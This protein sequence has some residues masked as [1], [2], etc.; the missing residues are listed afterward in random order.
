MFTSGVGVSG[1]EKRYGLNRILAAVVFLAACIGVLPSASAQ[2]GS[3]CTASLLNRTVPVNADGSFAL[4]N[5]P[6]NPLSLYRVRVRCIAPN[7]TIVQGMSGFLNLNASGSSIDIGPISFTGFTYPPIALSLTIG[8]DLTTLSTVG[9][10]LQLY[11]TATYPGGT[12]LPVIYSDSGTTYVSS[13]PAVATVSSGGLVT[14]VSAGNVT[15]TALNEGMA[16]TVQ[17]QVLIALDTDGDGMPD[18]YEIANGFNPLNPADAGEDAD[19]DGLTNLQEYLLGTNPHNPD[20]DGDGLTD[21]Q[22]VALGTNPL[23]PDTDGDGL[24]DGQEVALG[25]NPLNP[26]TDGDGIPDGIEV[27]LGLNPLVPDPTTTVQGRV[28]DGSGNPVAGASTVVFT[29]FTGFTDATGNFSITFVPN[30]LGNI[31]V[32]AQITNNGQILDGTSPSMPGVTKGITNVG[33]IQIGVDAGAVSGVVTN[34][35]GLPVA[36]AQV[37]VTEGDNVRTTT[38]GATGSYLVNNMVAG[39]ITVVATDPGTGL[40]GQGT[41]VLVTGQSVNINISLGA[42]GTING[43]VTKADGVTPVGGA[44]VALSGSTFAT[45]TADPLG[46]YSFTFV[47]LGVFTIDATDSN[48]NH[49]RTSGNLFATGQT[50]GANVAFLG[51]GTVTGTVMDASG[52]VVPSAAITL[53]SSSVFGGSYQATADSNGKFSIAG[54]FVGS[55]VVTAQDTVN[56]L[57]GQAK[58]NITSDGQSVTSNISLGPAGTISGTVFQADGVTVVAGAQVTVTPFGLTTTTD[59]NGN[60]EFDILPVGTYRV[61]VT[62]SATGDQGSAS[63]TISSQDQIVTVNVTLNGLGQ[64][65]VTVIDGGGNEIAG[66][67]VALTSTT[68]FGGTQNGVTQSNGTVTFN[69]VLA[70]AFKV[71]ATNPATQLSGQNTG[72]VSVNTT[73]AI[74]VQL[75][76][77]GTIQ[78]TVYQP[79]GVTP[80]AGIQLQLQGQVSQTTESA[81]DGTYQFS[82]VPTSTYSLQAYDSYGNIRGSAT[83]IA[84]TT[85][86]QIVTQN[87]TLIGVGTVSGQITNPDGSVATGV[88][89]TLNTLAPGY[90]RSFN[91]QSDVNGNYSISEVPV[92]GFTVNALLESPTLLLGGSATGQMPSNSSQVTANIQ[93]AATTLPVSLNSPSYLY[94][95]NNFPFDIAANGTIADGFEY[96]FDGDFSANIG[97][98]NLDVILGSSA[99]AFT[100]STSGTKAQNG[101]EIDIQ[102]E[103]LAGLNVTRKVYVSNTG[104]FSRY[105]DELNNPTAG[106]I[107]IGVRFTSNIRPTNTSYPEVL[108]T[109]TGETAPSNQDDWMTIGD[110][111]DQDPM[112]TFSRANF[113]IPEL[114][115]VYQGS[116]APVPATT[117][118]FNLIPVTIITKI[119]AG[120]NSEIGQVQSEFDNITIPAGGTIAFLNFVAQQT[121]RASALASAQRLVQLPSEALTG[122]SPTEL[123][124]IV[125]FAATATNNVVN[126]PPLNANVAGEVLASDSLTPVPGATVTLQSSLPYFQRLYSTTSDGGGN[127]S[128]SSVTSSSGNNLIIPSATFTVQASLPSTLVQSPA[129]SGTFDP[130]NSPLF[131]VQNIIFSDTGIISGTVSSQEGV[132]ESQGTVALTG[133][134]FN[135]TQTTTIGADGSYNFYAVPPGTYTVVASIPNP[136]GTGLTGSTSASVSNSQTTQA[137]IVIPSTGAVAGTVT[138]SDGSVAVNATVSLQAGSFART[139][140]TNTGGGFSFTEVP[141]STFTLATYDST[142][143]TAASASV[144]I[145]ADQTLTQNLTLVLGGTVTGTV[146]ENGVLVSGAKITVTA[147]NGTFTATSNT[148]GVY[149]VTGV[150]PGNLI[151]QGADSTNNDQGQSV[152]T[153]GLSGQTVQ[154][155]LQLLPSGTVNGT[156]YQSDGV[157]LAP[158]AQVLICQSLSGTTCTG[159][160][161]TTTSNANGAYSFAGVPLVGFTVDVTNPNGDRGRTTGQLSNNGQTLTL[162]VRLNGLGA[163][164]VT[165]HDANGNLI[166]NAQVT[167]TGET[168]FGGTQK[169]STQSNGTALFSTVLA[170]PFFVSATDPVTLLGGSVSG[171]VGI[172]GSASVTVN[173]QP[174]GNILGT[175]YGSDGKTPLSNATI[176][177]TGPT[178][179]QTTSASNGSYSFNAIPLGTYTVQMYDTSSRLRAQ[180]GPVTLSSNGQVLPVNLVESALVTSVSPSTAQ[181]GQTVSLTVLGDATSFNS[182]TQ[183]SFGSGITVN[184][185]TVTSATS[186]TLNVTISPIATVGAHTLTATTGTQVATGVNALSITASSAAIVSVT[187]NSAQANTLGTQI[188]IVGSNT[189]FTEATPV[190]NLG[191]GVNPTQVQVLSDTSLTVTVN[192]SPVAPLQTNT[193]TVSTGGEQASLASGFAVTAANPF[194]TSV[195][196]VSAYQGT[197]VSVTVTGQATSF[198]AGITSANFGPGVTVNS[199]VVNSTTSATVSLSIDPAAAVGVRTVTMTTN[200]Q[201]AVGNGLFTVQAGVPQIVS[202]TPNTI[203]VGAT[204]TITITG[205]FTNFQ[206][207]V[208]QVSFSGNGISTGAVTVNSSTSLQVP[209]TVTANAT[210]GAR[211]VTVTTNNEIATLVGALTV[212]SGLPAITVINPN[213]GAP[214]ATV[215]VNI[216]GTNTNFAANNTQAT[217]GA[218]ISVGGAAEGAFG[219][220]TVNSATSATATL[221]IDPAAVL[222]SRNVTVQT[223]LS[224]NTVQLLTVNA[225]FTVQTVTTTP[226]SLVSASPASSAQNVPLNAMI[227]MVFNEPLLTSTVN[228]NNIYLASGGFGCYYADYDGTP[229]IPTTLTVDASGRIVTMVPSS[230]LEVG[231]TYTIC[232]NSYILSG[233]ASFTDPSGNAYPGSYQEFTTGF[234]SNNNGPAFVGANIQN[235]DATVPTNANVVLSFSE[236]IDPSTAPAAIQVTSGGTP[237]TGTLGYSTDYSQV[238][239]MPTGGLAP[240]T[241]YTVNYSSGLNDSEGNPLTNPGTFGFTTAAG[242]DN[243]YAQ[244]LTSNP[245]NNEPTGE[246]PTFTVVFNEPMSPLLL[247]QANYYGYYY[248][249]YYYVYNNDTGLQVPG[250]TVTLS[251]DGTT[252]SLTIPGP[253]EPS[254]QY[255]WY[256][257]AENRVGNWSYGGNC[258][259]TGTSVDTTAPTVSAVSPPSG[260]V[261]IAPNPD[262]QVVMSKPIDQTSVA[263]AI[264]PVP[265]AGGAAVAGSASLANDNVTITFTPTGGA[266]LA[267]STNYTVTVAGVK[268][269]D[270]NVMAPYSWNFTTSSSTVGDNTQGTISVSPSNGATNV[271][272]NTPIVLSFSKPVDPLSVNLQS[273][274]VVDNTVGASWGGT[275]TVSSDQSSATFTPTYPYAGTHQIC[276]YVSSGAPIVDLAGNSFIPPTTAPCFTTA[277]STNNVPPTV[278]SIM[279]PNASTGIGPNTPVTVT[280][281]QPMSPATLSQNMALFT[282]SALYTSYVSV[283]SDSTMATFNTGGLNYSTAFTVVVSPNVTDASGTPLGSEFTSNFTT[284]ASDNTIH[285]SVTAFRPGAGASNV[286]PNTPLIFFI[287]EAINPATVEGAINV[288]VNGNLITGSASVDATNQIVTF[289]PA[290]PLPN[291]STVQVWFSS[292]ATDVFG[293]TLYNYYTSF[294]VAPDLSTVPPS[295]VNS[296]PNCCNNPAPINTVVDVEFNKPINFSTVNSNNFYVSDCNGDCGWYTPVPINA[297]LS[298]VSP[299]VIRL[300]PASALNPGDSYEVILGTGILDA[301]GLAYPGNTGWDFTAS[302]TNDQL[303]PSVTGFAPGQSATAIGDNGIIRVTFNKNIDPLTITPQ[304]VTLTS[305]GNTIPYTYSYDNVSRLTITPE[306]ALPDSSQ[307][308]VSVTNG[309]TDGVGNLMAPASATFQTAAGPIFSAPQ[310]VSSTINSGDTNVPISSVFTLTFNRPMD[311]RTFVINNTIWLE[312]D[313]LGQY[314]PITISFSPDGTQLTVQPVSQ[315]AIGRNYYIETCS[316]MDLTGNVEYCY[317]V[318]FTTSVVTLTGGPQIVQTVPRNGTTNLPVNFTPEVQFDRPISEPSAANVILVGNGVPVPLTPAFYN[319]DTVV[320]FQPATVLQTSTT[321]VLTITG[322]TD[323]AGNAGASATVTFTTGTGINVSY[324]QVVSVNPL[325]G[326]T[327]GTQPTIQLNFNEAIDPIRSTGWNFYNQ[328]ANTNVAGSALN[329][330]SDLMSATITYPGT[331]NVTTNYYFGMGYI[332]DL[333]GNSGYACCWYFTTGTGADTSPETVTSV[334]PANDPGGANPVPLNTQISVTLAKP[335]DPATFTQNVLTLTPAVPGTVS[336]SY[337]GFTLYYNL[338]NTL[339]PAT[340]YTINVSGFTDVDGNQVQPFT[341]S[342]MTGSATYTCCGTVVSFTPANGAQSVNP[343]TMVVVQFDRSVY[344]PSAV[345]GSIQLMDVNDNNNLIGGT[346]ALSTDGVTLTFTPSA[347]L[348]PNSTI[349]TQV[350][351][352]S[353]LVDLAGN[354][355]PCTTAQFATGAGTITNP[356]VVSVVPANGATGVGPGATITLSFNESIDPNTITQSNFQLFNGYTNLQAYLNWSSDNQAVMLNAQLPYNSTVTVVVNNGVVDLSGNPITAPFRSSFSTIPTPTTQFTPNVTAMRP[357]NGSTGVPTNTAITLYVSSPVNPSTVQ[358]QVVVSQNGVPI[359]GTAAVAPGGGEIEFTPAVPLAYNAAVQVFVQSAVTDINGNPFAAYSGQF[360]TAANYATAP[361]T[362]LS[363]IPGS[364]GTVATNSIVQVQFSKP[365]DPSTVTASNFTLSNCNGWCGWSNSAVATNITFPSPNVIQ[366]TPTSPLPTSSSFEISIGTGIS[367]LSGN[368]YGGG[369]W[370]FST[371]TSFD[372]LQPTVAAVAPANN[373]TNIGDNATIRF[374]FNKPMDTISINSSTVTLASG[375]NQIAFSEAFSTPDNV[376][377]VTLTPLAPLPDNAAVTLSLGSAITDLVGQALTAQTVTFHTGNGPDLTPPQLVSQSVTNGQINV[378]VNTAFTLTFNKPLDPS[379]YLFVTLYSYAVSQNVTTTGSV[380]ADGKTITLIPTSPLFVDTQY[381]LCYNGVTDVEGNPSGNACFTFN[382]A[383]VAVTT[384]PQVLYSVPPVNASNVVDNSIIEVIFDRPLDPTSLGQVTLSSTGTTVQSTASLAW[385]NAAVRIAPSSILSPNATYAATVVGVKDLSGNTLTTPV[386]L[387]FSTGGTTSSIST[388]LVS[389]N[390]LISGVSTPLT[391]SGLTN[392]DVGTTIQLVFSQAVDPAS[393]VYGSTV[394]LYDTSLGGD[395]SEQLIPLSLTA[396]SPDQTTFTLAPN[397]ELAASSQ[398]QLR[399]G[400]GGTIYDTI[401]NSV[402]VNAYYSFSTGTATTSSGT[403]LPIYS[404]GLG[405]GGVGQLAGGAADPNWSVNNPNTCC[406]YSGT[407]TVLSAANLYSSWPADTANSQWIAWSDTSDGG[408]AGYT[409]TQT[410]DLNGFDPT[411]AAIQGTIWVDDGG[412]L[413]LNNQPIVYVDNTSWESSGQ[414]GV[415]FSIGPGSSLFQPGVNTLSVVITSSDSYYEGINVRITSATAS[416]TTDQVKQ[417]QKASG[418]RR[419]TPLPPIR[420]LDQRSALQPSAVNAAFK[421]GDAASWLGDFSLFPIFGLPQE[422]ASPISLNFGLR[423]VRP[424]DVHPQEGAPQDREL[425]LYHGENTGEVLVATRNNSSEHP[426]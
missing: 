69:Q 311:T 71:L 142:T 403:A 132:V 76:P 317:Y 75:Q 330:A 36:N 381:Q 348:P 116:N 165:V 149:S 251:P 225:G 1:K 146:T 180:V 417:P 407:A 256:I 196:P 98:M 289:T 50:V 187:P 12:Q 204:Q 254:T 17:V 157:T 243:S 347:P 399:I 241:S 232:M 306:T 18:D 200:S 414:P 181:Q 394:Q 375:A 172:N 231:E 107:T 316:A 169:S 163:V 400:Y 423:D 9:Q 44:T 213:V 271:A 245:A 39:T 378:P 115:F 295:V 307:V 361:P 32:A 300:T 212:T 224:N 242:Q 136:M 294:S 262:I 221:T 415:P 199:V 215:T 226:P 205:S 167:L 240:T 189:H 257:E 298:Q 101:Q 312:D 421:L 30:D 283:S 43:V 40:Q 284:I 290:V 425:R 413:Y 288:A 357:G 379:A 267:P 377:Y 276:V 15:I 27:R 152:G 219:P 325:S 16:A 175:A 123:S 411:T 380:S 234:E 368:A 111:E 185:S 33:T 324:P 277:S 360:M 264:V 74:T 274:S 87:L 176:T 83:N 155:N 301:T 333:N 363:V 356:Q 422:P 249:G 293:N 25:T 8:E 260:A 62:N 140:T 55:Y 161:A 7:G 65:V 343:S 58:G 220:V 126:L 168:Q 124:E 171:S 227:T 408:P 13:N 29:Y 96:T 22:E 275:I 80:V 374:S 174:A 370:T 104:Y 299:N 93:L 179:R 250:T 352:S 86:G 191:S 297:T 143:N 344:P 131:A 11:A 280:F 342:F 59:T 320:R 387:G 402:Y 119:F 261:N 214:N 238:T 314:V 235:G 341:S 21:G 419:E 133:S 6:S 134:G 236:P 182:S 23:N 410:F 195:S 393:F 392:V 49:G 309:V 338:S 229:T 396:V 26:D 339:A 47:P 303:Q 336:Y 263:N 158:G 106:P 373:A 416:P 153:L 362:V 89:I 296:Y 68:S 10:T 404:T 211:T 177:I 372:A 77:A 313:F 252:F 389:T 209:V 337:D 248:S 222:A 148:Q 278:V 327:T 105:L 150:A 358:G 151:V 28:V 170:G 331:L 102:Q 183:F 270:G 121:S 268:D 120:G 160:S 246:N 35:K 178:S 97:A 159:Y 286:A 364:S 173:L 186:A 351:C 129:V 216:T 90:T 322:I 41:G 139:T 321:Y 92:G 130:V 302:S 72:S 79:D 233:G 350:S 110:N 100:G 82:M 217:F 66:A 418:D 390:L 78:G 203:G 326:S 45:T 122:I 3:N 117:A 335:I 202:V 359:S 279:P 194:L 365:I 114:M 24:T 383:S 190:V 304:D 269:V 164:T 193:V 103:N 61:S 208:S 332:Y 188:S 145:V 385:G 329:F 84:L 353:S 85:Q 346:V 99:S 305:G 239:F 20:T 5:V 253:L 285:P 81:A 395:S 42:S 292:N 34:V 386:T 412:Y 166:P 371:G 14:A 349:Q 398:F 54:V 52:N 57:G 162:N 255:C 67:Q 37:T 201:V 291:G 228:R 281:S 230:L 376:T 138:R 95:G 210:A 51:R 424:Q 391:N 128:F 405:T 272:V 244:L 113:V 287:N 46:R 2:L 426:R 345:Y 409:F 156:V 206:A 328:S 382:T 340:Q 38:T 60:Y 282:G 388:Q 64:V 73:A 259:V 147:N 108:S 318:N 109:S 118:S 310:V 367:D 315:L 91:S 112:Q 135:G 19:G 127:Y 237:V 420:L 308:T 354:A 406:V 31:Q 192:I 258:F 369:T 366:L 355:F 4:G 223:T 144:T 56:R 319:G 125:N 218:G 154:I 397:T 334:V 63:G 384:P 265:T 273:F 53:T 70:G 198:A 266:L 207:G 137:N 48:G 141:T 197:T 247:Q 94:D 88:G 323:P 184:S 401:G